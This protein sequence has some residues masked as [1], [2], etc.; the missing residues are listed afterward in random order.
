MGL[1]T[2][3]IE[4]LRPYVAGKPLEELSRERGVSDAVK[5][6]SNENPLGASPRV[7]AA[8]AEALGNI[9]RYPDASAF[10]LRSALAS[11]LGIGPDELVFG[12]GSNELLELV[13]R[14]FATPGEHIVFG[15]PA[16]VVYRMAALAHGI[17]FTAV[18]LL[19]HRHDLPAMAKAV[20]PRTKILF[21]ANP[22]NPTGTYVTRSE[23]ET[24]LASVPP[25]VIVVLDEAYI[26]YVDALDYPNGLALRAQHE[27]LLVLRTFSKA[28]GLAGL[29][30]GYA[31]GPRQ[32]CGYME[33]V[34][35]PFNI[36]SLA[37]IAARVAL[38][39][40]DHLARVTS[41]NRRER[42]RVAAGLSAL[43]LQPIPSQAN[44][45]CVDLGRDAASVFDRLLDH[46]VITRIASPMNAL[47]ISIGTEAE[48]S[49]MLS[50]MEKV[51]RG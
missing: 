42:V 12:N 31:I 37:Q 29:R 20:T 36:N 40:T 38:A 41:L 30:V 9:H 28:Y 23:V 43:G 44:F 51:L 21:I 24:L 39:D 2:P 15:E 6:A 13:V 35:A 14:T 50:A 10:E 22:N 16:F 46:G 32:L 34:R 48:N 3:S 5:L 7:L 47:R 19:N 8:L 1:V 17:D 4:S 33:R 49:R 11:A 25:E 27:R 45:I 26:E 18:P